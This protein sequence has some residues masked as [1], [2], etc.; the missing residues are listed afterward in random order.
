[1][2]ESQIYFFGLPQGT[3]KDNGGGLFIRI[4]SSLGQFNL[5]GWQVGRKVMRSPCLEYIMK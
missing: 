3:D 5:E 2:S 1:M 4:N